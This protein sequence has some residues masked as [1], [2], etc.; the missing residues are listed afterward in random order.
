LIRRRCLRFPWEGRF[1]F[2]FSGMVV[3]IVLLLI[4][5]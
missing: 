3:T 1:R 2:F 5:Y 4:Y